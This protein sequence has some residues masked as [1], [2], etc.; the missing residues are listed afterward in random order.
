MLASSCAILRICTIIYSTS[1]NIKKAFLPCISY[2]DIAIIITLRIREIPT[3][4]NFQK[5][6]T[7]VVKGISS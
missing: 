3:V 1:V 7:F 5:S 4:I 6:T 2:Y